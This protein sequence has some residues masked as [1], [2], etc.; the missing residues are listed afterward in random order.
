MLAE[1]W[2]PS[3]QVVIDAFDINRCMFESNFP[4]HR[5]SGNYST[6]RN[7]FKR[8][9]AA[10]SQEEKADLF[11]ATAARVYRIENGYSHQ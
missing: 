6:V 10:A 2:C 5:S 8:I 11:A 1:V 9:A 3:A 7:A 4:V